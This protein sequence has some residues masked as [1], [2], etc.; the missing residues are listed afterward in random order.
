V[1]GAL[2]YT[3]GAL[4]DVSALPDQVPG[5]IRAHEVFHFL[6]LAG[7]ALDWAYIRQMT[8]CMPVTDLY[9]RP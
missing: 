6:V 5:L 8:V 2:A 1:L 9:S 7:V 3:V 4:I